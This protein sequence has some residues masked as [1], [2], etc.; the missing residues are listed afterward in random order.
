[1]RTVLSL[2]IA[3]T[4]GFNLSAQVPAK[5]DSVRH[6][7]DFAH[8]FDTVP[9]EKVQALEDS[10]VAFGKRTSNQIV[11]V[12]LADL[13][14]HDVNE[15]ATK[16]GHEWG[17]G[18]KDNHNGVVILIKPK[19]AT[20]R[21]DIGIA[22]GEGL[23]GALPDGAVADLLDDVIIPRFA[24]GDYFGG[25]VNGIEKI[26]SV[27]VKEFPTAEKKEKKDGG[28]GIGTGLLVVGGGAAAYALLRRKKKKGEKSSDRSDVSEDTDETAADSAAAIATAA[29]ADA[30]D[31][32][33]IDDLDDDD[34]FDDDDDLDTEE[35]EDD[36]LDTE[37]E[38]KDEYRFGGGKFSGAGAH[39]KW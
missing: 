1:M 4:L 32:D 39:R 31:D 19:T 10:L 38:K 16:I 26:K 36:D 18:D 11:V 13:A 12:T 29:G 21:G 22:V 25:V 30:T 2:V 15:I 33:D 3:L 28:S 6:I 14:D 9:A 34:D 7:N 23:E 24:E 20:E 5:P 35:E 8:M 37:E 17:V 27:A